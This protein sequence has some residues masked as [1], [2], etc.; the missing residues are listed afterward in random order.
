MTTKQPERKEPLRVKHRYTDEDQRSKVMGYIYLTMNTLNDKIYIGKHNGRDTVYL[1]SGTYFNNAVKKYGRK[2]FRKVIL[3][4]NIDNNDMLNE[5]EIYWIAFFNSTNRDIGYNLV[6]GG[7]GTLGII[8]SLETRAKLSE[9]MKGKHVGEL[10]PMYGKSG[11][12]SPTYGRHLSQEQKNRLSELHKGKP[13]SQETKEKMSKMRKGELHPLYGRPV[14]QET[15]D[16]MSKAL[17]GKYVGVN[18]PNYG[19][20]A[21]Q[22]T[23]DNL[24]AR[25]KENRNQRVGEN[26]SMYGKHHTDETKTKISE[27]LKERGKKEKIS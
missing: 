9:A 27:T 14:S 5:R 20:I 15:R 2:N 23:R 17:K 18:N 21:S 4:N 1:G 24:K 6:K 11:L 3:E 12:E 26:H 8:H 7:G 22:E 25:W 16:K 10:N 19:R 13:L